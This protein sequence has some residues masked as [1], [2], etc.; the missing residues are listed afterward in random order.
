MAI[1]DSI[2]FFALRAKEFGISDVDILKLE[3]ARVCSFRSFALVAFYDPAAGNEIRVRVFANAV[4]AIIGR[5]PTAVEI[6]CFTRLH[7]ESRLELASA[8]LDRQFELEIRRHAFDPGNGQEAW[9]VS[10]Y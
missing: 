3:Q 2:A 6:A 9:Q 4:G 8:E 10:E 1:V 7:V 5:T